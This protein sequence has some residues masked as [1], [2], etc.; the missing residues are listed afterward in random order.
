[1]RARVFFADERVREAY[2]ALKNSRRR[3][4]QHLVTLLDGAFDALA[5]DA[6]CGT[7]VPK[8]QIP[9]F[10][11]RRYPLFDNLWKYNLTGSW[12][13]MYTVASDGETIAVVIEW[14]DHTGYERRFGY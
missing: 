7:Q 5:A 14:L 8:R 3:E 13:L 1:M 6:F 11:R 12:R 9:R 4:D 10:Y 2:A